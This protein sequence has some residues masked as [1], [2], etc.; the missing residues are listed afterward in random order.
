MLRKSQT[1]EGNPPDCVESC[2]KLKTERSVEIGS[3]SAT[4]V[5]RHDAPSPT[6]PE[7]HSKIR[8]LPYKEELLERGAVNHA[9]NG[10]SQKFDQDVRI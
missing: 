1:I 10:I 2:I 9:G 8:M 7:Q 6:L 3:H 4:A 5:P